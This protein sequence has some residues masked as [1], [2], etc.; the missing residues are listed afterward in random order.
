MDSFGAC[1]GGS[2]RPVSLQGLL[3][4]VGD[5]PGVSQAVVRTK[6]G[7]REGECGLCK[8]NSNRNI[9]IGRLK[10]LALSPHCANT[11]QHH[12]LCPATVPNGHGAGTHLTK[13]LRKEESRPPPPH[14]ATSKVRRVSTC[15]PGDL[16][17]TAQRQST[18]HNT[19]TQ[20][21]H[22]GTCSNANTPLA[23]TALTQHNHIVL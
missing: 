14:I 10:A 7:A 17:R 11:T 18:E 16:C 5:C 21:K 13:P 19:T 3:D 8:A 20:D 4:S 15:L 6:G 2:T 1:L 22:P 23:L 9:F 12:M